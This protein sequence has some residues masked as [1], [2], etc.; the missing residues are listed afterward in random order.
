MLSLARCL[1]GRP[2][3]V[4]L[5]EPSDGVQPSIVEDIIERLHA[6]RPPGISTILLVEQDLQ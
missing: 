4:L 2:H 5:D 6:L 3:L 1:V